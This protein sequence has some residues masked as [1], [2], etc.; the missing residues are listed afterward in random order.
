VSGSELV[1]TTLS[2]GPRRKQ[3]DD[4]QYA[5]NAGCL[6][7]LAWC[8]LAP[9]KPVDPTHEIVVYIVSNA[10]TKQYVR[11][12]LA[13]DVPVGAAIP[14]I[15]AIKD[16]ITKKAPLPRATAGGS[17]Y[18]VNAA[19]VFYLTSA[20]PNVSDVTIPKFALGGHSFTARLHLTTTIWTWGDGD[21]ST[22]TA[23]GADDLT[24]HPYTDG[25]PCES[26]RE[27]SA[28][29]S[30]V[31]DQTGRFVVTVEAHWSGTF[32]LDGSA[33]NIPIPGDIYRADD[34]GAQIT[35]RAADSVLVP[36]GQP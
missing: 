35:V 16:E 27:C 31:Y 30:H 3:F 1:T 29:I 23:A 36:A 4:T 19:V 5:V 18:V 2:C 13:C 28:Y 25:W 7:Y 11:T 8:P 33:V 9:G 26:A 17:S 15:A 14:S 34:P 12:D 10:A 6:N 24:G 32:T 22:F 20:L 21:N